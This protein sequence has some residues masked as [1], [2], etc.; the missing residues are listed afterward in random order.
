MRLELCSNDPAIGT[1]VEQFLEVHT[2]GTLMTI[3]Q[4]LSGPR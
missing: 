3:N 2:H 1:H 4:S